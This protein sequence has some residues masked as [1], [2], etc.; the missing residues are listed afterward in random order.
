MLALFQFLVILDLWFVW[1]SH[2]KNETDQ[3][4]PFQVVS[5]PVAS[6]T[7]SQVCTCHQRSLLGKKL[8]TISALEQQTNHHCIYNSI[9]GHRKGVP[10][11]DN[12][13]FCVTGVFKSC[14]SLYTI[15]AREP[16]EQVWVHVLIML[17]HVQLLFF[18]GLLTQFPC[19]NYLFYTKLTLWKYGTCDF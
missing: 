3:Y 6:F 13:N 4:H 8:L 12:F 19:L 2:L 1:G 7:L 11:T 10:V 15:N 16:R 14:V 18:K 5:V 17:M 9:L